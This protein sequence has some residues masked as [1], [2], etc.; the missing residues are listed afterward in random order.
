[1]TAHK[2]FLSMNEP[3]LYTENGKQIINDKRIKCLGALG[4]ANNSKIKV[5]I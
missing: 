2:D 4:L 1:M 3:K 5:I